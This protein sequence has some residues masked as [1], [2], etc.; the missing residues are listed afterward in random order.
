MKYI[1]WIPDRAAGK[2]WLT[3]WIVASGQDRPQFAAFVIY[4]MRFDAFEGA[5]RYVK[6]LRAMGIE[7]HI[8]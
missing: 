1:I 5:M 4:A 3:D 8:E 2:L 7:G 6:R